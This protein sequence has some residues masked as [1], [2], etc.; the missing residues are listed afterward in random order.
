VLENKIN[1]NLIRKAQPGMKA[2][3]NGD[4]TELCRRMA[5]R[6]AALVAANRLMIGRL[7]Q[8]LNEVGE[9]SG[10]QIEAV[11]LKG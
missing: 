10:E 2:G 4:A 8:R 5:K 11:L 7:A 3:L 1:G 6:A 9:M